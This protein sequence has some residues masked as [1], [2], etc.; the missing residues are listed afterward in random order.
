MHSGQQERKRVAANV[1]D[2]NARKSPKSEATEV[3]Y[4]F[5]DLYLLVISRNKTSIE[6]SL[7]PALNH[8]RIILQDIMLI[9]PEIGAPFSGLAHWNEYLPF[10]YV[11]QRLSNEEDIESISWL[12]SNFTLPK[13]LFNVA[14]NNISPS[15]NSDVNIVN[16]AFLQRYNKLLEL[17]EHHQ[18]NDRLSDL[19]LIGILLSGALI[20]SESAW[21]D[22]SNKFSH[23]HGF[24]NFIS[25]VA[26]LL[27]PS[28]T[29]TLS[30]QVNLE[31]AKGILLHKKYVNFNMSANL[32]ETNGMCQ[33]LSVMNSQSFLCY[34]EHSLKRRIGIFYRQTVPQINTSI[35]IAKRNISNRQYSTTDLDYVDAQIFIEN[36]SLVQK[37]AQLLGFFAGWKLPHL[38]QNKLGFILPLIESKQMSSMGGLRI[39]GQLTAVYLSVEELTACLSHIDSFFTHRYS[40]F[41]GRL[42]LLMSSVNHTL[43]IIYDART[44]LYTFIDCG[45]LVS[46]LEGNNPKLA[47]LITKAFKTND[48]LILYTDVLSAGKDAQVIK[49]A[50]GQLSSLSP[51]A[52]I[53]RYSEERVAKLDS[54]GASWLSVVTAHENVKFVD[55]LLNSGASPNNPDCVSSPLRL[56]AALGNLGLTKKLLE[57]GADVNW[58]SASDGMTALDDARV[59][60]NEE[61]IRLLESS[62]SNKFSR[63]VL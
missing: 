53:H 50:F 15:V 47:T 30:P 7:Y 4:N 31:K 8:S 2:P 56:A 42:C 37:P 41:K 27:N 58:K 19:I 35:A 33:G 63:N 1:S 48:C 46:N 17:C 9:Y 29:I 51:Y 38:T 44:R 24:A 6:A 59:G 28:L 5:N 55:Y 40:E 32:P 3:N 16:L 62:V 20:A 57:A 13:H 12:E 21:T 49:N 60:G 18:N 26:C 34:D 52:E 14:L 43:S 10:I 61:M 23:I 45:Y 54:H 22:L 11:M 39:V 36:A 25:M